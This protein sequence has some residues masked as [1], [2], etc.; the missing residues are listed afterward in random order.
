VPF[1][2]LS[3][4]VAGIT[5]SSP[6][7]GFFPAIAVITFTLRDLPSETHEVSCA[8]GFHQGKRKVKEV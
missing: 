8:A 4:Q 6:A 1:K 5:V 7:A 2:W 3:G